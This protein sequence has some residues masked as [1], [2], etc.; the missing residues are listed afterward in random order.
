MAHFT[1]V[2]FYYLDADGKRQVAP[3]NSVVFDLD[4][5]TI[6]DALSRDY[7]RPATEGEAAEAA[8]KL[9]PAKPASQ[10]K[11]KGDVKKAKGDG[12]PEPDAETKAGNPGEDLA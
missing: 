12:K 8:A 1:K 4:Q 2:R 6:E 3:A 9:P 10:K 7:I 11:A 5:D